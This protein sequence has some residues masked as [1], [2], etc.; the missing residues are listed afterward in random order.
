MDQ[1]V[2]GRKRG[3]GGGGAAVGWP[4]TDRLPGTA[5]YWRSM[6]KVPPGQQAQPVES[7]KETK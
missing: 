1:G 7:G 3:G 4:I 2:A 5:G 6:D